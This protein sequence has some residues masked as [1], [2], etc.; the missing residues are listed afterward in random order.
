MSTTDKGKSI[1]LLATKEIEKIIAPEETIRN[2]AEK[3]IYKRKKKEKE[4]KI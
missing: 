4:I 3:E 2:N 1:L